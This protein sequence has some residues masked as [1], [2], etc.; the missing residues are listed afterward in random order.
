MAR[1]KPKL[2]PKLSSSRLQPKPS[3][4]NEELN[5]NF[6]FRFYRQIEFFGFNGSNVQTPWFVSLLA[7]LSD[8]SNKKLSEFMKDRSAQST[9]GYRFHPINWGQ[10]NIPIQR[11]Q[12]DWLPSDYKNNDTEFPIYQFQ[13]SQSTGR[14]IGFFDEHWL[15]N[16]LL[17]DPLHNMQPSQSYGYSVD[18]C[19]PMACDYTRLNATLNIVHSATCENTEC[20]YRHAISNCDIS[21]QYTENALIHYVGD[22][23]AVNA[24]E[25]VDNGTAATFSDIFENGVIYLM[26]KD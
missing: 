22:D 16:I 18:Q 1:I 12:L 8:L 10:K 25:L 26:N 2:D 14:V 17:L 4:V 15:F 20:G 5:W 7:R 9:S 19:S 13:I 6:S 3:T 23:V 24:Q 21:L 11:G